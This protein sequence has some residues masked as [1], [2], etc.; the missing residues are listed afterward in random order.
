MCGFVGVVGVRSAAPALYLG[1]QA[2]QH[3]GQDAAGLATWDQGR[4]HLHKDL[5]LISQALPPQ[6]LERMPGESGIAH[7]RYPTA[8][9]GIGDREDAQP[10][11]TR[12]PGI[13]MAHNG[14][15]TNVEALERELL[16]RGMH[17]MSRC[18]S[19]PILLLLA[20][21]LTQLRAAHHTVDD[22]EEALR[23]LMS[24]V[25]GAYSVVAVLEVDGRETLLAFRDPFGIRP[26]VFGRNAQG[27]WM[28]ASE[29][30]ALDVLDF[31]IVDHVPPGSMVLLRGGQAP[32]LRTISPEAPRHCIFERIY[33]ARPDTIMEEGRVNATRWALGQRLAEEW[34]KK[35]LEADVVVAIP[36]T[37]RD[38]ALA[39]AERL[40]I[41]NRE[42]FIKNRYSGRT[43]IMP[44]QATREAALRLKLNPIREV[45]EGKRVILVDDSIVRGSTMRRIVDMVRS[46]GPREVHLA[47]FSPPVANPCFYGIDMPSRDELIASRYPAAELEQR[48]ADVLKVRSATYISTEGL[49]AVAGPGMCTACFTGDYAIP[50][51]EEER[52]YILKNRGASDRKA[53][54]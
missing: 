32:I 43:F 22:V 20:D 34:E 47:I 35:G 16:N 2:I 52:A 5:G 7:V 50:V 38:A 9:V 45:F 14:N 25:K 31:N 23:R 41:P 24:R 4:V 36:D 6:L 53:A 44:N 29:S 48:L 49:R 13:I 8:G 18:D 15:V 37:S 40:G 39:M 42:G 30:V 11:L 33:F 3:R 51:S 10:F 19:E 27:A 17:V 54:V 21:E 26:A 1:L 28:V 46:L 12:R